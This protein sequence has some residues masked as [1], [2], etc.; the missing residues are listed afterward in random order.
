MVHG[1]APARPETREPGPRDYRSR[2][3]ANEYNVIGEHKDNDEH[4]LVMGD[5]GQPYDYCLTRET[6]E[7][8]EIDESWAIDDPHSSNDDLAGEL[9]NRYF[10]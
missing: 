8:V 1:M 7:P 10:E 5:D 2:T 4:L 3:M 9:S 6:V